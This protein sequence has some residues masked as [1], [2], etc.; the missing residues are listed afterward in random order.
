[1]LSATDAP[2][3]AAVRR[4]RTRLAWWAGVVALG[5]AAL[6][7]LE[8]LAAE[9]L[10]ADVGIQ[11]HLAAET[12]RGAVPLIDFEH[13]WNSLAWYH[14]AL[15][16]LLSFGQPTLW[17]FLWGTVA[18]PFLAGVVLLTVA[19]RQG[20]PASW[21]LGL[22]AVVLLVSDVPNGKYALPAL[23]LLLLRPGGRLDGPRSAVLAR[24]A[25]AGL[26]VLTHVELAVML[27]LGTALYDLLGARG[28]TAATRTARVAALVAGGLVLF[29]AEV[30]LYAALGLDPVAVV[31]FLVLDRAGVSESA[32]AFDASLLRPATVLAAF[33]PATLAL[34]F[35]PAVWRR[36]SDTTRLT[37]GLHLALGFIAIR[38][39]D[40]G[41][42]GAATTLL[43]LLLVLVAWDLTR[44]DLPRPR[45]SP[46]GAVAGVLGAGWLLG[47]LLAGFEAGSALALPALLSVTA[48]GAVAARRVEW[49]SASAGALAAGVALSLVSLGSMALADVR[50]PRDELL[51]RTMADALEPAVDRCLG[52]D[53]TAW[54]V[55]E[56]LVLYDTLDLTNPTPYYLFWAGFA[57]EAPRVVE[58]IED[59]EVP[60]IVLQGPWPVSMREVAPV[61]EN[62]YELCAEVVT[63]AVPEQG[64]G[65]RTVRI[66]VDR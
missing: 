20:L 12:A 32:V 33:W 46:A 42:V 65:A 54:V 62:R 61:V 6:V 14:L 38:K 11:F 17:S 21:L 19:R 37:A 51:E 30:A 41:H 36:L 5:L 55:P 34:P 23:W 66:W 26:L 60:A 56:P 29:S 2:A 59:G 16:Y 43:A 7:R 3:P 49:P 28:L 18:G 25:L 24:F 35:V 57:D 53:R 45:P 40:V 44:S 15:F 47:A 8:P 31:R 52:E 64:V 50:G 58:R 27:C 13:G 1:V 10:S 48:L 63:P 4:D 22:A 9:G 39:P